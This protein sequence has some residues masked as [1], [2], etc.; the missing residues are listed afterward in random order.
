MNFIPKYEIS[1]K[2][3]NEQ[4]VK[5]APKTEKIEPVAKVPKPVTK[6]VVKPV[7]KP[8]QK[9]PIGKS[10]TSYCHGKNHPMREREYSHFVRHEVVFSGYDM[11]AEISLINVRQ[12]YFQYSNSFLAPGQV[13]S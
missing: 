3:G 9:A 1:T 7:A 6:P 5:P 10:N 11:I 4:S 2:L 12:Y 13:C 8:K